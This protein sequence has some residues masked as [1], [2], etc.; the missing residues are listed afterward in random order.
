VV[1]YAAVD[2]AGNRG[3]SSSSTVAT[4]VPQ[5]DFAELYTSSLGGQQG[6]QGGCSTR[7]GLPDSTLPVLVVLGLAF[8]A[9][10]RHPGDHG[11]H[12]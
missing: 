6:E 9:R 3:P 4:P 1:I 7:P 11:D 10:R 12:E 8:A 2:E 5:L